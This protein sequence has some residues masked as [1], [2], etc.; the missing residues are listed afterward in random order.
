MSIIDDKSEQKGD[1]FF[2]KTNK[3][4]KKHIILN[5]QKS[6]GKQNWFL[7]LKTAIISSK[8][9]KEKIVPSYFKITNTSFVEKFFMVKFKNDN[10]KKCHNFIIC[11][12]NEKNH[13]DWIR[14]IC[15]YVI[16]D[17]F[18][19]KNC[20]IKIEKDENIIEYFKK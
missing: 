2:I 5:L 11:C 9:Y 8:E 19:N 4:H 6:T 20:N 7:I 1:F 12:N 3:K 14:N 18:L 16:K 13:Y 10:C 15:N 17:Y